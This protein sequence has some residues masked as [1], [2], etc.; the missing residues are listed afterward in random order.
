MLIIIILGLVTTYAGGWRAAEET[1]YSREVGAYVL[2]TYKIQSD[3]NIRNYL[4]F[5]SISPE[6][7]RQFSPFLEQNK[8]SV[9]SER[10][11]DPSTL[12]LVDN[13][14]FSTNLDTINGKTISQ[15]S[16]P[17][18]VNSSQL[19][20]MT[21]VGWAVDSRTGD[22]A[23]AVFVNI[24]NRIDVPAL[25]GID[26]PDVAEYFKNPKYRFSGYVATFSMS[27]LDKGEHTISFKIISQDQHHYF[28]QYTY[29]IIVC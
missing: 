5:G 10:I 2:R 20:T 3:E 11:I 6:T 15:M 9:F 28:M 27:I 1:R 7:I 22:V 24:D 12:V 14:R 29:H 19:E 13:P 26:R 25:Y 4:C 18:V 8:L 23:S 17:I 16:S 21:I